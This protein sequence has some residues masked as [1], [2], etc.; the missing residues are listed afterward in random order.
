MGTAANAKAGYRD[1]LTPILSICIGTSMPYTP[2]V[3]SDNSQRSRVQ[4][5][6]L[7]SLVVLGDGLSGLLSPQLETVTVKL[8]AWCITGLC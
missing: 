5:R 1:V 2:V 8:Q 6:P 3:E 7:L 4:G